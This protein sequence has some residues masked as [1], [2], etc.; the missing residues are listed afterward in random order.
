MGY[1]SN[2]TFLM[3]GNG[4]TKFRCNC[5]LI[6][7]LPSLFFTQFNWINCFISD[8]YAFHEILQ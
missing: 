7:M 1:Y 4:W 2:V 5:E 8:S 6:K 3:V